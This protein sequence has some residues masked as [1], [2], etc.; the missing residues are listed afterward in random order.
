MYFDAETMEL[1]RI[2]YRKN[3]TDDD[4]KPAT[5]STSTAK[6]DAKD[7]KD[8]MFNPFTLYAPQPVT[9]RKF[10]AKDM[11]FHRVHCKKAT[12]AQQ[13]KIDHYI[14]RI[15]DMYRNHIKNKKG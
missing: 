6:D 10:T 13:N 14:K 12:Q 15:I 9:S 5:N 1:D 8:D 7:E 3:E 4:S 2:M 11:N